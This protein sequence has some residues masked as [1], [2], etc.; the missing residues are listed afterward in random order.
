MTEQNFRRM[1]GYCDLWILKAASHQKGVLAQ[2]V[3]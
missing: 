1:M 2:P 3:G